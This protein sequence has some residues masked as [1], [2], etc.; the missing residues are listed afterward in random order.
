MLKNEFSTKIFLRLINNQ[1]ERWT[2]FVSNYIVS[3]LATF[4]KIIIGRIQNSNLLDLSPLT[5]IF[6]TALLRRIESLYFGLE[7]LRAFDLRLLDSIRQSK[8]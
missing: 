5:P 3:S 1:F 8:Y 2:L 4:E 6:V 7:K